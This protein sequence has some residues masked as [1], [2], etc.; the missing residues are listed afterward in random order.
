MNQF[1]AAVAEA[2]GQDTARCY[3]CGKCSAGCPVSKWYEWPNHAIVRKLQYGEKEALLN[4][5]ALWL[6]VGCE[7]CGVRCPNS[8]NI[9]KLMGAMRHM[10]AAEGI[11]PAEPA[12]MAF[13]QSF[14]GS[15]A[16]HGRV[17]EATMLATYKL[18][19]RDFFTDLAEG[20]KL[21]LKGKIPLKPSN[22]KAKAEIGRIFAKTSQRRG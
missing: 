6:C 21:F 14:T 4:S 12:V 7:T 13:H 3:Q 18:K 8:I 10:A 19:T 1:A 15:V 9:S 2:S 11:K 22:V 17:H 5:H 20:L 16:S